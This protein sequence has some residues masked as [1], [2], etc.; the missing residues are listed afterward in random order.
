MSTQLQTVKQ[1]FM[2]DMKNTYYTHY[3]IWI[4]KHVYLLHFNF[5][6]SEKNDYMNISFLLKNIFNIN[7]CFFFFFKLFWANFYK[8]LAQKDFGLTGCK[9]F[10]AIGYYFL[11]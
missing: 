4:C 5:F 9:S 10:D 1:I 6:I 11:L 7:V 2:M 8:N 3:A